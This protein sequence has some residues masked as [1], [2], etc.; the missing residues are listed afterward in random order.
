MRDNHLE[1]WVLKFNEVKTIRPYICFELFSW[2]HCFEIKFKH[3]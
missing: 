2:T 1:Y 3:F